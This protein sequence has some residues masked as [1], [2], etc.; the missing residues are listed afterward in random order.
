MGRLLR[1]PR[2]CAEPYQLFGYHSTGFRGTGYDASGGMLDCPAIRWRDADGNSSTGEGGLEETLYY[3]QD[4][5]GDITALADGDGIVERVRYGMAGRPESFP[6]ADVNFDGVVDAED[7]DSFTKALDAFDQDPA[8]YDPRADLNRDGSV[9]GKDENIFLASYGAHSGQSGNWLLSSGGGLITGK[10]AAEGLDN[11][12]GWRGYWYDKATQ[13]Y[14]VRHRVYDPRE[15]RWMQ[16]DPLGFGAGDQDLYRYCG[17]NY[18]SGYDPLGL[19]EFRLTDLLMPSQFI[20]RAVDEVSGGGLS[21]LGDILSGRA[22]AEDARWEEA[23]GKAVANCWKTARELRQRGEYE[24]AEQVECTCRNM[25]AQNA[26]AIGQV[27]SIREGERQAIRDTAID[28]GVTIATAGVGSMLRAAAMT[29]RAGYY[30]YAGY[31]MYLVGAGS[32]QAGGGIYLM[33]NGQFAAGAQQFLGGALTAGGG[34]AGAREIS[35]GGVYALISRSDKVVRTG[36]T[37]NL[38]RREAQHMRTY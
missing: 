37:G 22:T 5:R 34:F 1:S 21:E 25:S 18:S 14:H 15:G 10:E 26:E 8:D 13:L 23:I 24:R 20:A 11:R 9:D 31:N 27:N 28:I 16:N 32:Y 19:L 36:M 6:V 29:S 35:N 7:D 33:A 38:T 30:A 4:F 3:L 12:F 2:P 17:G